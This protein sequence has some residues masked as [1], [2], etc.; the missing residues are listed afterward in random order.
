MSHA[1]D[2]TG[3]VTR[4]AVDELHQKGLN[5][6]LV[7][8]IAYAFFDMIQHFHHF[9]I[10]SAVT[11]AFQRTD[12]GGNRRIGIGAGR[13]KDAGGEGGIVAAAVFGVQHQAQIQQP[14]FFG[15]EI[16]IGPNRMQYGFGG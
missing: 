14:R 3:T 1:V 5:L 4:L 7:F 15:G 10:G 6:F 13:R 11:G 2:Q 8:P 16:R 12:R 9:D